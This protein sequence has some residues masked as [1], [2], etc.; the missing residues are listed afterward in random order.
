MFKI[1]DIVVHKRDICKVSKILKKYRDDEDY[2]V[3]NP[4]D[5][6]SLV[7]YVSTLDKR[8]SLRR[9]ITKKDAET[10]VK[11]IS[12]IKAIP[13]DCDERIIESKY[14]NLVS[15]G[16]PEGLIQII[17]TT[18]LRQQ[19][20]INNN[21]KAGEKDKIYLKIAEKLLYSEFAVALGKTYQETKDYIIKQF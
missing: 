19:A 4:T 21:Q 12:K 9:V 15:N 10:L 6:S 5:D 11:N 2:Y 1:G 8:S 13:I 14:S 18:F 16:E 17:K 20:R 3:L 7:I